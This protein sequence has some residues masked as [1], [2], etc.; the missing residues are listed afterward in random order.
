MKVKCSDNNIIQTTSFFKPNVRWWM[1]FIPNVG[2]NVY[3]YTVEKL[4]TSINNNNDMIAFGIASHK[5]KI[6][7]LR[8]DLFAYRSSTR[9]IIIFAILF[10]CLFIVLKFT[11][12]AIFIPKEFYL[13]V[14]VRLTIEILSL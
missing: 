14:I 1:Q 10:V 11:T 9:T 8:W 13:F 3:F 6:G 12:F 2:D 7:K 4:S 5:P